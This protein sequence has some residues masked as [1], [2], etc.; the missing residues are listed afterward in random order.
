MSAK[1]A[2]E[3]EIELEFI[4]P[5]IWRRVSVPDNYSLGDLHQVIQTAMGWHDCH[6]HCFD[7]DGI[8]YTFPSQ[9]PE[10]DMEDE[11]TL[12]LADMIKSGTKC[13]LYE[14]DFGDSW[15]HIVL[16]EKILAPEPDVG[17]P[18]CIKGRRACPPEDVGGVW[19]YAEFLEA[20]K[21]P[22]H[23]SYE[24]YVEWLGDDFDPA[25]FDLDEVNQL[26]ALLK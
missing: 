13:F 16:L 21:D 26:L 10:M 18:V 2:V 17:Y 11:S 14:Y 7:V 1:N 5:T 20:I 19:G 9:L 12:R 4:E 25:Y 22:Q 3:L 24:M 6:L 23:E 8:K 15:E